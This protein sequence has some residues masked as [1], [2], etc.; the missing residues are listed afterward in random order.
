MGWEANENPSAVSLP[1]VLPGYEYDQSGVTEAE[2]PTLS[3]QST[4]PP[5]SALLAVVA[6][7]KAES[8]PKQHGV[9]Q[10]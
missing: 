2:V 5:V 10:A 1:S 9:P 6:P 4:L 7:P 8:P 3:P